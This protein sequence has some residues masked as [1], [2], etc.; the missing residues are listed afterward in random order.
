LSNTPFYAT[1]I[2]KKKNAVISKIFTD[3]SN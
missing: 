3:K 1:F 2:T